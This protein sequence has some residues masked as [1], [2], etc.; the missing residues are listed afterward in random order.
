MTACRT[1]SHCQ[2]WTRLIGAG[3]GHCQPHRR[4]SSTV[5]HCSDFSALTTLALLPECTTAPVT[6]IT[7]P[8]VAL[9]TG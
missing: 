2:H 8:P 9:M 3:L 4:Y 6:V 5:H 7:A 1:C